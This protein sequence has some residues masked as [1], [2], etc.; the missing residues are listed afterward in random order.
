VPVPAPRYVGG[1]RPILC[2]A[3]GAS[4]LESRCN[5]RVDWGV[6]VGV[7]QSRAA[8]DAIESI[9]EPSVV[10]RLR[11]AADST[12]SRASIEDLYSFHA[13]RLTR[14]AFLL[15]GSRADAE[16]IVQEAFTALVRGFGGVHNPDAY[17]YRSVVNRSKSLLR[18]R[19]IVRRALPILAQHDERADMPYASIELTD[20][21]Q[22]LS[23]NQRSAIVLRFFNAKSDSEIAAILGC[24]PATVRS[25]L[26]RGIIQLRER[27]VSPL[28]GGSDGGD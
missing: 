17:L 10:R 12:S 16:E 20:A 22:Q 4:V 23:V 7:Q 19:A 26:R 6:F 11:R 14:T 8:R 1:Q 9:T 5:N 25:H 27:F 3:I 13:E 18:H 21:L 24:Q 28:D 2:V 15:T